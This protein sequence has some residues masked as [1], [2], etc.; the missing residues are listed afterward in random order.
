M[1]VMIGI[2]KIIVKILS[3]HSPH[4]FVNVMS[5]LKVTLGTRYIQKIKIWYLFLVQ[6]L[7][8]SKLWNSNSFLAASMVQFSQRNIDNELCTCLK[9]I[10][11]CPN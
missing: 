11:W 5:T 8:K 10:R 7:L 1:H 4:C 2:K 9:I 3:I 6:S